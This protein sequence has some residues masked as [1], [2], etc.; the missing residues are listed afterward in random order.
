MSEPLPDPVEWTPSRSTRNLRQKTKRP[1]Q[2][3]PYDSSSSSDTQFPKLKRN[4]PADDTPKPPLRSLRPL[5]ETP[6]RSDPTSDTTGLASFETYNGFIDDPLDAMILIESIVLRKLK[7][8][9]GHKGESGSIRVRNGSV[10]V[11][12]EDSPLKRWRDGILWSL[13]RTLGHFLLYK[14]IESADTKSTEDT[15]ANDPVNIQSTGDAVAREAMKRSSSKD[16]ADPIFTS[17][18]LKRGTQLTKNGFTKRTISLKASDGLKYR[19]ISY[20]KSNKT[21]DLERPTEDN[22]LKTL[23]QEHGTDL[24]SLVK[25]ANVG[26]KD[27]QPE[28]GDDADSALKNQSDETSTLY[29]NIY[30]GNMKEEKTV[31]Q[32]YAEFEGIYPY[33]NTLANTTQPTHSSFHYPPQPTPYH[34]HPTSYHPHYYSEDWNVR[35]PQTQHYWNHPPPHHPPHY[36]PPPPVAVSQPVSRMPSLHYL[37]PPGHNPLMTSTTRAYRS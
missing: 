22:T 31:F 9:S 4:R 10:I 14:Q 18:T 25:K 28:D 33:R 1:A 30:L 21:A 6:D 19:V 20:Y 2:T 24:K 35:E 8:Y 26:W 36:P 27:T 15:D 7:P 32:L 17:K 16:G 12:P 29:K 5:K 37:Q 11:I 13:S 23:M 3:D 34:P